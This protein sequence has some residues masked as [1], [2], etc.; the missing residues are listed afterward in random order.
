LARYRSILE[1][2]CKKCKMLKDLKFKTTRE[3]AKQALE[4][5]LEK[6]TIIMK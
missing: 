2:K 4:E 3:A 5:L 6:Y 1:K